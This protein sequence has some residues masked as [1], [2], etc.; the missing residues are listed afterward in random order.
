MLRLN[1]VEK[2]RQ[3]VQIGLKELFDTCRFK[4][5]HDGDLLICQQNGFIAYNECPCVGL[6]EAG[7]NCLAKINSI[8]RAGIGEITDDDDYF[9]RH[10]QGFCFGTSELER[11]IEKEKNTYL[12]IWENVF[13][14]RTL[15]QIINILNQCNYDWSLDL[16]QLRPNEKSKHIREQIIHR[17]DLSPKFQQIIKIAYVGQIRNAIAHSQY[18]C[19]QG[20]I[21]YDNYKKDKYSTLQGLSFEEWEQKYI[22][23]FLI[24]KGIFSFLN[25]IKNE[26]YLKALADTHIKAIPVQVP[27]N[28]NGWRIAYLYPNETGD[29][30]RFVQ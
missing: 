11:T 5:L 24:F 29:I 7:I 12:D 17:L 8:Y 3:E 16:S 9:I 25:D 28:T 14:L 22:Y 20:G 26:V 4:L 10:G 27:T 30:W 6:G 15:T 21:L 2:Y 13:F 23:S 18:H 1:N 19:V